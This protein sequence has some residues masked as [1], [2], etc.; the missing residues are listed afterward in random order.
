MRRLR[1]RGFTLIEVL[2]AFTILVASVGVVVVIFGNGLRV[3]ALADDYIQAIAVAEN[4]LAELQVTEMLTPGET[5]G[6][7]SEEMAWNVRIV[8]GYLRLGNAAAATK[9]DFFRV[10]VTVV[11]GEGD[12]EPRSLTLN[13]LLDAPRQSAQDENAEGGAEEQTGGDT[14]DTGDQEGEDADVDDGGG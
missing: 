2:V 13:T 8:P 11:W 12:A 7:V 5:G 6:A 9:P 1:Q 4:R 3:S 14:G 10:A